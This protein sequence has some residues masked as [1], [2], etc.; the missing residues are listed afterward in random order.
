MLLRL[1]F[2]TENQKQ[3]L[4]L[5]EVRQFFSVDIFHMWKIY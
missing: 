3:L 2:F 1:G 5:G 4:I